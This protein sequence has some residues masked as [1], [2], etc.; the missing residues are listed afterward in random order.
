MP[1]F[2]VDNFTNDQAI[3]LKAYDVPD[4][5][6]L[7]DFITNCE[8]DSDTYRNNFSVLSDNKSWVTDA[9]KYE[10]LYNGHLY[11]KRKK[12]PYE[13]KEDVYAEAVDFNAALLSQFEI[14]DYIVKIAEEDQSLD[15]EVLNRIISYC[16]NEI[17]NG[18]AVEEDMLLQAGQFGIGCYKFQPV[19]T[20]DG[21]IWPGHQLVDPRQIGI[22]PRAPSFD[23]A[24][25]AYHKRPVPTYELQSKF[26]TFADVIKPDA[27]VSQEANRNVN[28][29]TVLVD[30]LGTAA[31]LGMSKLFNF[32]IGKQRLSQTI[33]NEFY[34]RDP[35]TIDLTSPSQI[36]AWIAMNPGFG[37]SYFLQKIQANYEKRWTESNGK[38]TVKEFP[39]GKKILKTRDLILSNIANP[40]PW[41]P[42]DPFI[43]YKRPNT[44]WGKGVIEK[45]REPAQNIQLMTAGIAAN[46]DYRLRGSY[47]HQGAL[48]AK[49]T[50]VPTDPNEMISVSGEIKP[51]PVNQIAPQDVLNAVGYRERKM[52][53]VTGL[54]P[55]SGGVNPTGN[56][57]GNQTQQ[58]MEAALGKLAPR[59][60]GLNRQRKGRAKKYL[61]FFRNYCTDER[62]IDF[63]SEPEQKMLTPKVQL[64][65]QQMMPNPENP[66]AP[67]I[68]VICNDVTKGEYEYVLDEVQN[69]PSTPSQKFAQAQNIAKVFA[70]IAPMAAIRL[71]LEAYPGQDKFKIL[72]MFDEAVAQK[73][74][75]EQQKAQHDAAIAAHNAQMQENRIE[76][77]LDTKEVMAGAKAQESLAWVVTELTKAGIVIP[78]QVQNEISQL[79]QIALN[80]SSQVLAQSAPTPPPQ[81]GQPNG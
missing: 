3:D 2:P 51:I 62:M 25:Y 47:Y 33:L 78:P 9:N 45:M 43:C 73:Q 11:T 81:E 10:D 65:Q 67:M 63:L 14:R 46:V 77:E 20:E 1:I 5:K 28:D 26:P 16:Y 23:K 75:M 31:Y 54:N 79:G 59:F 18:K 66:E 4:G 55:I 35:K 48:A 53:E 80:E 49:V 44:I 57:S 30:G 42:F 60:R 41:F 76:R 71:Q 40:Y 32:G 74:T 21:V 7:A 38:L 29:G 19:Q 61:W 17:N 6:K 12:F 52:N 8:I 24:I 50:K 39:F 69:Q 22:S 68:S 70:P 27:D 58:L 64:N 34:I 56:Y 13:C 36:Q 72:A 15:A 37:S